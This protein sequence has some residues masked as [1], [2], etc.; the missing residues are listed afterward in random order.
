MTDNIDIKDL[1]SKVTEEFGSREGLLF[2]TLYTLAMTGQPCDVCL[3]N[4]KPFLDVKIDPDFVYALMYGA[5]A[6]TLA[7]MLNNITL[8]G[9]G[10]T[11]GTVTFKEIWTIN[12]MPHEGFTEEQLSSVDITKAD[13]PSGFGGET[14]K[15]MIKNTYHCE[16]EK[17]IERFVRRF[18]AS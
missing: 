5:G 15:E 18:I 10:S 12:P 16:N 2:H 11:G 17:E 6:A 3:V 1:A 4:K 13:K 14:L 7:E 9:G 8:T